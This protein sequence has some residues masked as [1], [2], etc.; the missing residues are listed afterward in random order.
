[1]E[2]GNH[3]PGSLNEENPDYLLTE[4]MRKTAYNVPVLGERAKCNRKTVHIQRCGRVN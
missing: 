2:V 4:C 1:M 3:S